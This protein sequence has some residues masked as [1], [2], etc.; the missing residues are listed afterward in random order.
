MLRQFN[1][2]L[3]LALFI[4]AALYV[5][6]TNS[7]T[8]TIKLGPTLSV[9]T[10]A[11]VIY[12][13]V[14]F[15]GAVCASLVALYFSFKGYLR[16]R[17]LRSAERSRQ[18]FFEMFV[19][20]RDLMAS[21][22]WGAARAL[23]QQVINRDPDNMIAR[24][25]LSRCLEA[26][27]DPKEALRILDESRATHHQS[28]DLLF[29]AVELNRTL[30]NNTA[31]QDNLALIVAAS[32]SRRAL[33]VARD[34]AESLGNIDQAL[35]YHSE[36]E[37]VGYSSDEMDGAKARLLFARM[38]KGSESAGALRDELLPFVKKHPSFAPAIERLAEL[39]LDR[40]NLEESAELLV[41][42]AKLAPGDLSK[43]SRVIDLWLKL[44]PGEPTR[45]AE[46]ALAAAR[47]ATQ[48]LKGA[49]RIDGEFVIA[50]TLL[51][52]NR[53]DDAR[54]LLEGVQ[55]LADK[56]GVKLSA[57]QATTH[58]HLLGLALARLGQSRDTAILWEKLVEPTISTPNSGTKPPLS[59]R[60]EPSPTFSTP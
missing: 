37:R 42:A 36:I 50:K 30:G 59:D 40:G 10:Y 53:Y 48:G 55:S 35:E 12:I 6:L 60:R 47:S 34:T 11:G 7:G 28:I 2:F 46:R 32:P 3:A 27:G 49:R 33:E 31:A 52:V 20:A 25:E 4:A 57:S 14:F 56:E 17:K 22:E 45:R 16:E 21:A 54:T 19:K 29:R 15:V 18:V 51:A 24:V 8:A 9:T 43:W 41:K 26:L 39:E 38:V 58:I 44:A 13:A 23:W 5:T 1:R